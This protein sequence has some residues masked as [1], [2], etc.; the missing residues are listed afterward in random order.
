MRTVDQKP[1]IAR[2]KPVQETNRYLAFGAPALGE[3]EIGEVVDTL[4]SG[5]IGTGARVAHAAY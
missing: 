2:G 1:A 3:A 5:W 4:R